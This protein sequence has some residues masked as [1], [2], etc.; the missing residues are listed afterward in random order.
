LQQRRHL[1]EPRLFNLQEDVGEAKDQTAAR[2]EKVRELLAD[3]KVWNAEQRPPLW[4]PPRKG[5]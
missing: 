4:I 2:P 1:K 3:W 5:P